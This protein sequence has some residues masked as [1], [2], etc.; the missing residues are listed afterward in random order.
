MKIAVILFT[1]RTIQFRVQLKRQ[2]LH[3]H[4]V[5]AIC[6][7]F[8]FQNE[9]CSNF[10]YFQNDSDSVQ[11]TVETAQIHCSYVHN[12]MFHFQNQSSSAP[13]TEIVPK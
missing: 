6:K 9:N 3:V 8:I 4:N 13:C 10:I 11:N 1:F 2:K 5:N 7:T 12:E